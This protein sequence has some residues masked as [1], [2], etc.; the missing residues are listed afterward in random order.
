ME[1]WNGR[2]AVVTGANSGIG[3]LLSQKL[4]ENGMIVIGKASKEVKKGKLVAMKCDLTKDEEVIAVFDQIK[5]EYNGVDVCI[6]NAG[7]TNNKPLLSGQP[8]EWREMLD[9]NVVAL[10]LVAKLAVLSMRERKVDDGHIYGYKL[11]EQ[12]SPGIVK[13]NFYSRFSNERMDQL[14]KML[15][16]LEPENIVDAIMYSLSAPPSVEVRDMMVIGK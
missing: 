4:L 1:K 2:V 10:C 11:R 3:A 8:S 15:P 6:N 13:T 16:P 14:H 7:F 5:K 9:V 12:V